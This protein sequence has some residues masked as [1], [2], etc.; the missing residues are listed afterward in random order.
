ME[1]KSKKGLVVIASVL[2]PVDDTRMYEKMAMTLAPEGYDI[3][4]IGQPSST[5]PAHANIRFE[6]LAGTKRLSISRLITR[7]KIGQKLLR[8]Q[9]EVL[10]VNTHELLIVSLVNRI[11]FGTR[12]IYDLRENYYRNVR[13]S[14]VFHPVVGCMIASA[15]RLKE[16]IVAPFIH[17]F[18]LA[19]KC[20]AEELSFI[21]KRFTVIE[22]K[23]ALPPT[24]IRKPNPQGLELIFTGTIARS[25]GVFDA[26]HLAKVLHEIDSKV[27]LTIIGF[28][29]LRT[30]REELLELVKN[31]PFIRLVGIENLVPH[32]QILEAIAQ[33][34]FGIIYYP[35]SP[36]TNRSMPTKL[37]EYLAAGLPILTWPNQYYSGMVSEYHAGVIVSE[38][39][40]STLDEMRGDHF[41][42]SP[43][44]GTS[45]EGGLLLNLLNKMTKSQLS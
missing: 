31:K 32:S 33:A 4:I 43:I 21:R 20:Y 37:F 1:S 24:F 9:P 28:C 25:T 40:Q 2:N 16:M 10:I 15:V 7:W 11:L 19:E 5:I 6:A 27:G 35:P 22:N 41:Y 39:I 30:V 14:E 38:N 36:H 26:I 12:I 8:F 23:A 17:H 13:F 44:S 18:I 34:N 45:W 29:A 42:P 3:A